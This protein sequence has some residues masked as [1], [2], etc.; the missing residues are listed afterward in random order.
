MTKEKLLDE[1][2]RLHVKESKYLHY[3]I[4]LTEIKRDYDSKI[5]RAISIANSI[6]QGTLTAIDRLAREV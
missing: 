6:V 3:L 2:V 5:V 1:L 4:A